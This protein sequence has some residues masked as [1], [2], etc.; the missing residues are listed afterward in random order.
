[1]GSII[2]RDLQASRRSFGVDFATV[3]ARARLLEPLVRDDA[4][5]LL[6]LAEG[7]PKKRQ[8]TTFALCTW[9]APGPIP[10]CHAAH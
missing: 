9:F 3:V 6:E 1:M 7:V 5:E 4:A 2:I 8:V 10:F